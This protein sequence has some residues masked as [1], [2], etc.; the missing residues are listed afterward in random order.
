MI[1]SVHFLYNQRYVTQ[2]RLMVISNLHGD[3]LVKLVLCIFQLDKIS[4]RLNFINIA[5]DTVF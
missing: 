3:N 5:R 4:K 2:S 1:E